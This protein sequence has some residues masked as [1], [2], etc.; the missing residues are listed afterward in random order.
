MTNKSIHQ[1]DTPEGA[2]PEVHGSQC[3]RCRKFSDPSPNNDCSPDAR[4]VVAELEA[5]SPNFQC[6]IADKF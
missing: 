1:V 2:K 5:V 3:K 4:A 6:D